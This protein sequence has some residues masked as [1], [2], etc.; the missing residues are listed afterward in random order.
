MPIFNFMTPEALIKTYLKSD[1][2]RDKD[3]FA[4]QLMMM[5]VNNPITDKWNL[6][7]EEIED[8]VWKDLPFDNGKYQ[9]SCFGRVRTLKNG[10]YRI[11]Y[12]RSISGKNY[13]HTNLGSFGKYTP[14]LIHIEV[15]KLFV[16]NPNNYPIVNHIDGDKNNA[17]YKNLEWCTDKMNNAHARELRLNNSIGEDS[18]RAKITNEQALF[19]FNSELVQTELGKMFGIS[20]CAVGRIKT[21]KTWKH[22]T[23]KKFERKALNKDEAI[24]IYLSGLPYKD[25]AKKYN[26]SVSNISVIKLGKSF[27]DVTQDLPKPKKNIKITGNYFYL[28]E[29][30]VIE[31]FKAEGSYPEISLKYGTTPSTVCVIKNRKRW[32]NITKN[33]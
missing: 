2:Q 25:L 29:D 3:I 26:V 19:I 8:E 18:E 23:G 10:K 11:S 30:K 16:P 24:E 4:N 17:Y 1:N 6:K 12:Y 33:L 9:I 32:A 28:G 7:I 20:Q 13:P 31:I 14:I 21:G 5:I 22:L 15:A 27:A